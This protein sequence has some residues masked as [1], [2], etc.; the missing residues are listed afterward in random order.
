M[1]A[2][3]RTHI[4]LVHG[5]CHGAWC[6]FKVATR[7][8]SAGHRITTPDLAASGVDPRPLREVPTFRDYTQPLLDIL[9]SLP[10]GEKA[11]LVG[12]SLGGMNIALASELFPEKVAAAVF[13][14]AFM[15]DHTL[16]PSHVLERVKSADM[17]DTE[18][19]PQDPE[20]KAANIL[21]VRAAGHTTEGLPV[22]FFRV[23]LVRSI[24][25]GEAERK[26]CGFSNR[27]AGT[28]WQD[29]T[30]G[31]SLMRV[32]SLFLEDLEL[33]QP[34]SEDRYG[35][36]RKVYIVCK[37]DLAII[38]AYQRWMMEKNPVQEVKELDGADHMAMLSRPDELAHCLTNIA[39]KYA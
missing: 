31:A 24:A 28:M 1:D 29:L 7:L 4:I 9:A 12:H 13:L 11:V 22:V 26:V 33:Q 5:A 16:R 18:I 34:Y 17:M 15:P 32:S 2:D 23:I 39:K 10:P 21:P 3:S 30:L 35:S 38:E 36:V 37:E 27:V 8:S 6:W 25:T 20:G 14:A 19:K